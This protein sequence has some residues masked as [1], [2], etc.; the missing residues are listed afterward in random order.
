MNANKRVAIN[1]L[2]TYGRTLLRMGLGLFTSRWILASLGEVDYGLMGVVGTL[3]VMVTFFNTVLSGACS[4]FFAFSIGKNDPVDLKRWFSVGIFAHLSLAIILVTVFWPVGELAIDH[5]LNIPP[6]RLSTAHW[7]FRISLISAF[8]SMCSTPFSAMYIATQ[9]IAELTLW[10]V[11]NILANFG[12]VYWLTTYNGD[13]WLVYA[14]YTVFITVFLGLG[15]TIRAYYKFPAC[16]IKLK[17][18]ID[19]ARLKQ[20][21][22]FSGWS[23]FGSLGYFAR[24]QFPPA[25]LNS[26]FNPIKYAFVNASYQVGGTLASYTQSMSS[27]LMG[28]F[29]PQIATLAGA[30]DSGALVKTSLRASKFGTFLTLLFAIPLSLE[31]DYLLLIWLKNT[32][33]LASAFCRIILLQAIIDNITFGHTSAIMASGKIK[34]YQLTTGTIT[35][36]SIPLIWVALSLGGG[37][38]TVSWVIAGCVGVC[39]FSRLLFGKKLLNIMINDWFRQVCT[40]IL[41]IIIGSMLTGFAIKSLIPEASFFRLIFTSAITFVT[42]VF[43]GWKFLFSSGERTAIMIPIKR[44]FSK[45]R[46]ISFAKH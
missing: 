3:I 44:L 45:F 6:D 25:L 5:Y 2:A 26:F 46:T 4:R 33:L 13:T 18:C 31:A 43:L 14:S 20:M 23:L 8:W 1:A 36:M 7:V 22:S 40:P 42:S 27:S 29:S 15:Q 12:F 35:V 39:S 10:E 37:P 30:N 41:L 38:L 9:N 28:A 24:A 21:F 16:K 19:K 32:P 11:A 34:W 17:Y